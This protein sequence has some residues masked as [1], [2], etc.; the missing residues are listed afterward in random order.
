MKFWTLL[1]VLATGMVLAKVAGLPDKLQG[2]HGW[3]RVNIGKVTSAGAHPAAKDVYVNIGLDRL[4]T[5]DGKYRVPLAAGVIFVKERMDPDTLTVTT[6]YVMEKK[7]AREGDWE[8]SVFEREGNGFKGGVLA[9]PAMCVGCHQEA[10]ASDWV[11]TQVAK[12]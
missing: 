7:S 9:N 4:L 6:L 10:K 2:Y 8:W 5:A 3:V 11:Y 1:L 12:R